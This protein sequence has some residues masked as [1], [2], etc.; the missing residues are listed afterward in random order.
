M[1]YHG[2]HADEKEQQQRPAND[3]AANLSTYTVRPVQPIPQQPRAR[4]VHKPYKCKFCPKQ[5]QCPSQTI[6]HE[7]VHTREKPFECDVCGSVFGQSSHLNV[8]KRA[9][10]GE[11]PHK[12]Q[13]CEK[14]FIRQSHLIKHGRVHTNER[15]FKC[16]FCEKTYKNSSDL[17][18]H[19]RG[20]TGEKPLK[21]K[22]CDKA[23]SQ[24]YP[25]NVHMRKRHPERMALDASPS[26]HQTF[27]G[28]MGTTVYTSILQ[29]EEGS[30]KCR[31]CVETFE[32]AFALLTHE[33]SHL[34]PIE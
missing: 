18:K 12:C 7:R 6:M 19:T 21:C 25:R 20:H 16:T 8:H 24:S 11:R 30:H 33:A 3:G 15:S 4:V 1:K 2:E 17:T 34:W 13:I 26:A 27:A 14:T 28:G 9:H 23:F 29:M 22:F 10:T 5:F 32:D 31:H